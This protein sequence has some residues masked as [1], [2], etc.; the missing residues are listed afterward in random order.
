MNSFYNLALVMKAKIL[1]IIL[2]LTVF[3]SCEVTENI[4]D[5]QTAYDLKKYA[6][7]AELLQKE[8]PKAETPEQQGNIAWQIAECYEFNNNYEQAGEW[9]NKAAESE[10]GSESI[11]KYA[12]MLKAQEKYIEAVQ[13]FQAYLKEEPYR[14]PE[15]SVQITSCELA[16]Q[17]IQRQADEFERDTYVENIKSLNSAGADFNPVAY[18]NNH[19]IFTTSRS[20]SSG[21]DYDKWTG[22]KYFD[23]YESEMK[24]LNNFEVPVVF[25]GPFNSIYNDGTVA[26]NSD[27]SELFFIRCGSDDKK[28]N[29]YC[30]LFVSN[31]LPDGGWSEPVAMPFFEDTMNIGTPCLSPDGNTL[32][33]AA[34]NPDG[35]GGADLYMS[36]RSESGWDAAVNIGQTINTNGNEVFPYFGPDGTFYFSSDQLPGMGGLDLFSATWKNGK[37]SNIK[38]LEYPINSGADDFGLLMIDSKQLN[39]TDRLA[40]GYF[41]SNR[42]N[43]EGDDD[44]YLFYKTTK[45]LRPPVYVLKGKVLQKVYADSLDVNSTVID[46]VELKGAIATVSYPK[47]LDLLAK[48]TLKEGEQFDMPVDS[49]KDYKVTGMMEG[50]F[51]ESILVTTKETKGKPGDTIVI[52]AEVVL[53]KKPIETAD[54]GGGQIKLKNIYYDLND[55]TLRIESF[56]ELDKLVDLLNENPGLTIQINS[57]TDVRGS[58]NFNLRLSR[59]RANSVVFYLV[60]KGIAKERLIAKGWGETLP[61]E[62]D[63]DLKLSDG[64]ILPKGTSLVEVLINK[65]KSNKLDFEVLHQFNRRTTFNIVSDTIEINSDEDVKSDIELK[66]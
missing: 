11:M 32:F 2:T 42:K 54:N 43:G 6:L 14:R 4:Q 51:N 46:T 50:Y 17:W 22:D 30:G 3:M 45:K 1:I 37:F 18:K 39:N 38:N 48:Y 35:F 5:G 25:E 29:D 24:S 28:I 7:A 19:V 56:S 44:I 20:T 34:T 26:F 52:Y 66:D 10:H 47:S 12:Y 49:M 64:T 23:L 15:M 27:Y 65:Y 53:N 58:D 16:L 13:Q 40:A 21:E 33:F 63:T 55:T 8:Y 36:S 31:A 57:H 59:G 9:Y 41:S 61:D 60:S 62:L